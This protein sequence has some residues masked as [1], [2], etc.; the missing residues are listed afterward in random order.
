RPRRPIGIR[1]AGPRPSG[2]SPTVNGRSPLRKPVREET[3]MRRRTSAD[4]LD[5]D[6]Q[7]KPSRRRAGRARRFRRD[8]TLLMGC[9][10]LEDRTMLTAITANQKSAI[11]SG[12]QALD[13][14]GTHVTGF[15]PLSTPLPVVG[16]SL[17][18][19]LDA[20]QALTRGLDQLAENYFATHP[21]PTLEG[22]LSAL[23]TTTDTVIGGVDI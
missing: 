8:R 19:V 20:N 18:Q 11:V 23:N 4:H 17:G 22:L 12:L 3:P 21:A 1:A 5:A 7:I 10:G 2:P 13:T 15:G 6:N 14:F 16:Q 9:E